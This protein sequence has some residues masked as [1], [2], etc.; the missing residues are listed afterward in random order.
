MARLEDLIDEIPD[1]ELRKQIARE[2]KSLKS[3]KWFGLVFEEHVPETVSLFGLTVRPGAVVQ[4]RT[5]PEE[6]TR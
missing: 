2:V 3:T 5:V 4:R 1:P 6:Q